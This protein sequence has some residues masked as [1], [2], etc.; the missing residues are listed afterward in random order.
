MMRVQN[1]IGRDLQIGKQLNIAQIPS[2]KPEVGIFLMIH[3]Q[4]LAVETELCERLGKRFRLVAFEV[5]SIHDVQLILFEFLG[6]SR[7]E[8]GAEHFLRQRRF[9]ISWT[10][11]EY[12][13]TF[14]PQRISYF[15]DSCAASTL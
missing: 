14:A 12:R 5:E 11:S 2:C 10:G 4:D 15:A 6:Q 13:T 9:I 7:L 8:G 3:Q 1:V